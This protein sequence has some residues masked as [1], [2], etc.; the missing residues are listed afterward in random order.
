MRDT[1]CILPWIHLY[2]ESDGKVLPCCISD[3]SLPMGNVRLSP[4]ADIW[5]NS[6]YKNIRKNMLEGRKSKSCKACY[7]N[8]ENGNVSFRQEANKDFKKYFYLKDLT[9]ADGEL[10]EFRLR[11]IDIRW[12]NICNF[13]CRSCSA[14]FSS[15]WAKEDSHKNVYT[16]SGGESNNDLYNDIRKHFPYVDTFY[17]AG[18]EPLLMETHYDILSEIIKLNKKDIKVKYNTNLSKLKFKDKSVVDYWKEI[19]YVVISGSLD[20]WSTRA[21]YIREGTRWKDIENNIKTIKSLGNNVALSMSS[22]VSVF[23]VYTIPDFFDYLLENQLFVLEDFQ[24]ILYCIQNPSFYTF[25]VIPDGLKSK[26]ID[27]LENN[28]DQ[29]NQHVLDQIE[30]VISFLKNS[31]YDPDLHRLFVDMT[32]ELDSKRS[33]NFLDVFPELHDLWF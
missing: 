25:D 1:F 18:G 26:I 9:A 14:T 5:N 6:E 27:K 29:F 33:R 30:V 8:E 3:H 21:E 28:K 24:P 19:D 15:S 22:V 7:K 31:T 10:S 4:L 20:S 13:K 2:A 32:K 23:N 12:S 17:F 11:Y 16:F